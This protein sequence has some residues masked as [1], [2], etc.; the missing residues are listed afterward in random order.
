MSI[1]RGL[2]VA[3]AVVLCGRFAGPAQAQCTT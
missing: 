2:V 1:D 3:L